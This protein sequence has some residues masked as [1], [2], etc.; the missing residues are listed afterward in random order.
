MLYAVVEF[1]L[2][3]SKQLLL[4]NA[5]L[6]FDVKGKVEFVY[7]DLSL[8]KAFLKNSSEKQNKNET[9]KELVKQI[10]DIVYEAEICC[11]SN[12]AQGH[13]DLIAIRKNCRLMN[14]GKKCLD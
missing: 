6:I 14:L 2:K 8:F 11:S 5:N 4:Y 7:N 3:N 1:L 13:A 12:Y 9:L 10:R